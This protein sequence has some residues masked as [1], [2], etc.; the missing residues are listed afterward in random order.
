MFTG[1]IEGLGTIKGA[2]PSG[3]GRRLTVDA[4]FVLVS[5]KIGDSI[6]VNGACLTV[7]AIDGNRFEADLSPETLSKTTFGNTRTGDRVNLER[8]LCLSDRIDGHLV[9]G[10]IDGLGTITDRKTYENSIIFTFEVSENLSRYMI[11]KGSVAVDGISLTINSCDQNSFK[12]SIIPHTAKLT[13]LSFKRVGGLVNIETDMIGKYVERFTTG[14]AS[15][16]R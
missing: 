1:I 14:K 15:P 11:E 8:A 10:H 4:D 2:R 13:T 5:T 9:S 3:Q 6:A 7:V 16:D 12:V